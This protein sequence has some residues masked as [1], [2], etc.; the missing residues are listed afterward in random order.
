MSAKHDQTGRSKGGSCFLQMSHYLLDCDAWRACSVYERS[1]YL[2][3]KRHFNGFNNGAISYSH[4]QAQED[5]GCSNKPVMAAFK[6]LQEKGF[7]RETQKG[8]FHW[9]TRVNG[10]MRAT[11]WAL[12]EHPIDEPEK[13][14]TATKDF[15]KWKPE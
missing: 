5:L 14:L 9:K 8:A 12:T 7:I 15:M 1:L 3:I 2:A 10:R 11:T 6:G 4:R 13:H